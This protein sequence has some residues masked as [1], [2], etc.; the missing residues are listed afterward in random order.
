[1][2]A[3]DEGHVAI[4]ELLLNHNP[5]L[6]HQNAYGFT[7]LT[8]AIRSG[9]I[10]IVKLLCAADEACQKS[11]TSEERQYSYNLKSFQSH[12]SMNSNLVKS[13]TYQPQDDSSAAKNG[14]ESHKKSTDSKNT[15]KNSDEDSPPTVPKLQFKIQTFSTDTLHQNGSESTHSDGID[16][17]EDC[18]IN[19]SS[20]LLEIPTLNQ[21]YPLHIAAEY[22]RADVVKFLLSLKIDCGVQSNLA[23][24]PLMYSAR[25][26]TDNDEK[27]VDYLI[28]YGAD[29][30][31]V[32]GKQFQLMIL[33]FICCCFVGAC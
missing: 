31:K 22:G 7:C 19:V 10:N 2:I 27:I 23:M 16:N 12:P 6:H 26:G 1:M 29:T 8:L 24:T 3:C 20:S 17:D 25:N 5:I 13:K 28:D 4:V 32:S 18:A 14:I 11:H 30:M 33:V 15:E 21:Q 9:S